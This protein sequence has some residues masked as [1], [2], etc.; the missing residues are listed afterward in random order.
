MRVLLPCLVALVLAV[1]TIGCA[2]GQMPPPALV[3]GAGIVVSGFQQAAITAN[4]TCTNGQPAQTPPQAGCTPE[5][6]STDAGAIVTFT[7]A[8]TVDITAAAK[9]WWDAIS[10]LFTQLTAKL[11]QAAQTKF[12]VEIGAINV[13]LAYLTTVY[14]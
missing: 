7:K 8:A 3:T 11:S 9:G 14:G 13:V 12:A 2:S 10:S 4:Q 1:S 6:N 5:L